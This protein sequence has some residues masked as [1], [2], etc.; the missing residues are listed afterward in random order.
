M[1]PTIGIALAALLLTEPVLRARD[2]YRTDWA[3]FEKQV[4]ALGL[5][6]RPA[7]VSLEGGA[8]IG[9]K[10]EAVDGTGLVVRSTR[11]T[12]KWS[13]GAGSARIPRE[14]IRWVQF[15]GRTGSRGRLI[16][17]MTGLCGG[18]GLGAAVAY[19]VGLDEGPGYI[20][21][22]L[23]AVGMAVSGL[24]AGYFI[25]RT[26]DKLAPEFVITGR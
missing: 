26:R 3:G 5:A 21:I 11:A 16:G 22:P 12:R 10:V 4:T 20:L 9:V 24:V 18:A 17:A 14:Q 1:H 6:G 8:R 7:R 15:R 19:R 25:G 23:A 13:T 2:T